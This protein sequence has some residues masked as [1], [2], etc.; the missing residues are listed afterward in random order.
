MGSVSSSIHGYG[1]RS[2]FILSHFS[3]EAVMCFKLT[4]RQNRAVMLCE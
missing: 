3:E 4:A 1:H 2:S